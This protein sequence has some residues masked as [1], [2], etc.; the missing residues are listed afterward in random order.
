MI[1]SDDCSMDQEIQ[2]IGSLK[3]LE[4]QFCAVMDEDFSLPSILIHLI[5][6]PTY[7]YVKGQICSEHAK[8]RIYSEILRNEREKAIK[9]AFSKAYEEKLS[10]W[11]LFE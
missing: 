8:G 2:K 9:A 6:G 3:D 7:E 5:P 1:L 4:K 10:G 11:T